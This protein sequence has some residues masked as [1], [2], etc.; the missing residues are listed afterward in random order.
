MQVCEHVRAA[1]KFTSIK[2][3]PIV[4]GMAAQKQQRLLKQ[5][6]DIVVGTPGRLWELMSG[7]ESH[8]LEVCFSQHVLFSPCL[9]CPCSCCPF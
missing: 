3:V 4:G 2:V 9:F 1:A 8:L 7:G 5:Q 6:P